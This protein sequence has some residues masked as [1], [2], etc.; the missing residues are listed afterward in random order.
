MADNR[1]VAD[2]R[3]TNVRVP[4]CAM[5]AV[6]TVASR[7]AISRD[8]AVRR[9]LDEHVQRQD[10]VGEE[11]RRTHISTVLR[12]PRPPRFRSQPKPG[13]SL[14]LRV[15]A[16]VLERAK[17]LA[18][19]LPGQSERAHRDYAARLL[20]DAVMTA[21][22]FEEPFEDEFLADL[23][24]L[25]RH[26]SAIGLWLLAV[27]ATSSTPE[28]AVRD[29]A[30]HARDVSI[31]GLD[32]GQRAR[33]RKLLLVDEALDEVAWHD[34][35]RFKVATNIAYR[36][37]VGPRAGRYEDIL[38]T[39]G[40]QWEKERRAFATPGAKASRAHELRMSGTEDLTW[41]REEVPNWFDESGRGAGAVWR[42]RR[43]VELDDLRD[44]LEAEE[45][46][47]RV[48]DA[49]GWVVRRPRQWRALRLPLGSGSD[50][51]KPCASWRA[52]GQVI[53]FMSGDRLTLWPVTRCPQ[54]G[55][56]QP[57]QGLEPIVAAAHRVAPAQR[58]AFIESLLVDWADRDDDEPLDGLFLPADGAGQHGFIEPDHHAVLMTQAREATI[59]TMHDVVADLAP[60]KEPYR[61]ILNAAAEDGRVREFQRLANRA[62]VPFTVTKAMWRWPGRTIV[63]QLEETPADALQWLARWA[64][65][66][67]CRL[68]NIVAHKEWEAGFDHH[69]ASRWLRL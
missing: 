32:S 22:A 39:R 27:A 8:A 13:V 45:P 51:R 54:T 37:L 47:R 60:A 38:Y 56:W 48:V 58:V 44:W 52:N 23:F 16:D 9:L 42:A 41:M 53:D 3:E 34:D 62:G 26:G 6:T 61:E 15:D 67:C 25:P 40:T 24:P 66:G 5:D 59:Q 69:P 68:L 50:L 65:E 7:W 17:Q 19:R 2:R 4:Q 63:D 11:D 28:R 31:T 12:Y 10:A 49:P 21:I 55:R 30:K 1:Q 29:A 14:R 18:L 43:R 46:H 36:R 20:T 33:R 57:V 35:T 64:Y